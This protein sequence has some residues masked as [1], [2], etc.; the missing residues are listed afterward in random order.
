MEDRPENAGGSTRNP[1]SDGKGRS[2]KKRRLI[3]GALAGL[4]L[5][6]FLAWPVDAP[7]KMGLGSSWY[8][9]RWKARL[10]A[11]QSL[12]DVK[13]RFN[14]IESVV[15]EGGSHTVPVTKPRVGRPHALIAG[16]SDGKWIA[17]AYRD[18]HGGRGLGG[19][20]VVSRDSDGVVRVF[21]GH[22]CGDP[23][24]YGRTVEEFYANLIRNAGI[25]TL[26]EQK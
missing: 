9:Q 3:I 2:K 6:S 22:V 18:S 16:F 13:Q 23:R 19:G 5:V 26:C 15:D 10:L 17:C 7:F 14:C 1:E 24:G 11:C 25:G 8:A 21:F 4:L 12:D 20:T